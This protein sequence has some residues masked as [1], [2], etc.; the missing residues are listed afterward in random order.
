MKPYEQATN[1]SSTCDQ[2]DQ[3]RIQPH[4][5]IGEPLGLAQV[6]P[7]HAT[8]ARTHVHLV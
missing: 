7:G 4:E 8:L 3:V 2:L 6:F 5:E 1:R